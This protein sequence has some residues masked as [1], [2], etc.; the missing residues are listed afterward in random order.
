MHADKKFWQFFLLGGVVLFGA[1]GCETTKERSYERTVSYRSQL[2]QLADAYEI[3][4]L[5]TR[6]RK[7]AYE[8]LT[9]ENYTVAKG[10]S[11]W[12]IAQSYGVPL[13]DLLSANGAGREDVLLIGQELQIPIRK[14]P[15]NT[16]FYL[17]CRGDTLTAIARRSGC[18][19]G[20]I[21]QLNSI[22]GDTLIVGQK[23]LVPTS[24]TTNRPMRE[25][26]V[27]NA[28]PK[29]VYVVRRG[30]TLSSIAAAYGMTLRELMDLNNIAQADHIREGQKLAIVAGR[31]NAKGF[32]TPVREGKND[33]KTQMSTSDDDL[34]GFFDEDDLFDTTR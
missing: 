23:I 19:V 3:E 18:S 33:G 12:R 22:S 25:L 30:D 8:S 9:Y 7:P 11:Y 5:R 20:E 34:S 32:K 27:V 4:N 15:P 2:P 16:E 6:P 29:D 10:D 31:P 13:R 17:V 28:D 26:G 1:T 24:G 14:A 21:R